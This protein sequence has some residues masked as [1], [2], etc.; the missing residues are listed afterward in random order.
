MRQP[1]PTRTPRTALLAAVVAAGLT[2]P[3]AA[4]FED[5]IAIDEAT[6]VALV[7]DAIEFDEAAGTVTARGDVEVYYGERTL[8][9]SEIVYDSRA[10]RI[11]ASGPLT[12][13]GE[14][15]STIFADFADL[16][17]ELRDGVIEGARALVANGGGRLAAVEGRRIDDRYTS[18]SKAVYSACLVCPESPTPLWAIRARR[19]VHDDQE[20]MVYY[21]DA[22][23]EVGGLPVAYLP[24]FAHPDPSVE[25]KSGFLTPSG[26]I[27]TTYGY[28]AKT[29]Y[30]IVFDESRD[31][32]LTP[33]VTTDDGPILELEYRQRTTRGGFDLSGSGGWLSTK[34][35]GGSELRGHIFGSGRFDVGDLGFGEGAAA[36]FELGLASDDG[37]L[38]RYD[39]TRADRLENEIYLERYE[40]AGFFDASALYFQSLREDEAQEEIPVALPDFAWRRDL[41]GDAWGDFGI[42]VSGVALSRVEGRDRARLTLEGDW[43]RGVIAPGGVALTGFAA[44]RGDAYAYND[45]PTFEEGTEFRLAPQAGVEAFWPLISFGPLGTQL[46]EPGA[47]LI[48]APVGLNPDEIAADD[49]DED[50]L[51]VEFDTTNLFDRNRSPGY[52]RI[53][54]GTRVNVGARYART[55][56]DPLRVDAGFGR[57]FRLTRDDAFSPGSG[58]AGSTSDYVGSVAFAWGDSAEIAHSVRL[59]DEFD[60][61]RNELIGRVAIGPARVS[62]SYLNLEAD[63]TAGALEDRQEATL[64]AEIDLDPRW[65]VGGLVRRDLENSE[66][67]ETA[68]SLTFRN[69]CALLELF[70]GRDFVE[71]DDAP[72]STDFGVRVRI[73]GGGD[74]RA[75]GSGVCAPTR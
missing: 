31:A 15:G 69:E 4:Q 59:S 27:S 14:E 24:F 30:F 37:Y 67:V 50:S 20:R 58:L 36:G 51:I 28:W 55:G 75:A 53:E 56:D 10:D 63:A 35:N 33:F 66:Y 6:P 41:D 57:V 26:G 18:L 5:A 52:D 21:E 19:V 68:A 45:D 64:A 7:A 39:F 12:L 47:Q 29:P 72:A 40:R 16:D 23:F 49:T 8:T 65:T 44:L 38:R 2:T 60:F 11:R 61:N 22:V 62:G 1:R 13:R 48:A 46:I 43:E 70:L 17:A 74:G 54:S 9:A 71:R 34:E 73:F 25:R 32:T 3:A 42:G